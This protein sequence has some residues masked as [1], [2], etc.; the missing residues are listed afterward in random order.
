MDIWDVL[1]RGFQKVS[2]SSN[3]QAIDRTSDKSQP[4]QPTI[5]DTKAK[6]LLA[7]RTIT[8]LLSYIQSSNTELAKTGPI[9]TV[10]GDR[11]ELGVLDALSAILIRQHEITLRKVF[12]GKHQTNGTWGDCQSR[13]H[14]GFSSCKA[15]ISFLHFC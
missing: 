11:N 13:C 8:T 2:D 12:Y 3:V 4:S 1:D 15:L 10:K 5:T 9:G 14:S 6:D 7:F